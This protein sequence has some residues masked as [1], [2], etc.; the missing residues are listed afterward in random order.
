MNALTRDALTALLSYD[1]DTGIFY[2]RAR[3]V[4]TFRQAQNPKI[5][6]TFLCVAAPTVVMPLLK[7]YRDIFRRL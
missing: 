4:E 3:A 7:I 2:W 5:W 6:R 1:P